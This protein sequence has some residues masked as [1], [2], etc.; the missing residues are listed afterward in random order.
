VPN[1]IRWSLATLAGN[2]GGTVSFTVRHRVSTP[3]AAFSL[4][5]DEVV[6]AAFAPVFAAPVAAATPPLA[7]LRIAESLVTIGGV[8]ADNAASPVI[9]TAQVQVIIPTPS[10]EPPKAIPLAG[11]GAYFVLVLF[12]LLQGVIV[13]RGRVHA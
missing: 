10:P 8:N 6:F 13:I 2:A 3:V 4:L 5:M 9:A 12:L 7:G 11:P 1:R